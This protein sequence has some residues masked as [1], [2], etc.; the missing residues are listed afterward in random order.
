MTEIRIPRCHHG[1]GGQRL[2]GVRHDGPHDECELC[3]HRHCLRCGDEH[4]TERTCV[5]CVAVARDDLDAVVT[6]SALLPDQAAN[7]GTEGHLEAARA[8]PGGEATVMLGPGSMTTTSNPDESPADPVP[9]LLMLATWEDDWRH[10]IGHEAAQHLAT[11]ANAAAYLNDNLAYAAQHHDAFDEFAD[12]MVGLRIRLENVLGAGERDEKGAPCMHCGAA[13][14]RSYDAR[15]LRD[16]WQCRRC[17]LAWDN[18]SYWRNVAWANEQA[19][20]AEI[21]GET[22]VAIDY[23]ARVIGRS[24]HTIRTWVYEGLVPRVCLIA[25]RR[26]NFVNLET[27]E[28]EHAARATRSRS[29]QKCA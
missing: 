20:R 4:V 8:I 6:L 12:D 16:E 15:G 9:P 11:M 29:A 28:T 14:V 25:G 27:V 10:V 17:R 18:E 7:G 22:W 13:L 24:S 21:G 2:V 26:Q 19:K 5:E 3:R 23:A 1:P